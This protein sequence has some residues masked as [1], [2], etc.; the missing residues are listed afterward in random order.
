MTSMTSPLVRKSGHLRQ[1]EV[2]TVTLE[3]VHSSGSV[4]SP[5]G[6]GRR[7][8]WTSMGEEVAHLSWEEESEEE[9]SDSEEE[10]KTLHNYS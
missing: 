6:E 10:W 7:E 1:Q 3:V 5:W 2:F 4:A 8:A 9:S